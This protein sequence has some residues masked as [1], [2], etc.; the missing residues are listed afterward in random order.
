MT[1]K[2]KTLEVRVRELEVRVKR[3]GWLIAGTSFV[4]LI[5]TIVYNIRLSRIE[6]DYFSFLENIKDILQRIQ[7]FLLG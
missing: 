2:E 3:Q 7:S 6:T 4:L 1:E 5:G